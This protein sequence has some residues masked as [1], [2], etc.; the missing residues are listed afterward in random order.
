MFYVGFYFTLLFAPLFNPK[1]RFCCGNKKKSQRCHGFLLHGELIT[2]IVLA[3]IKQHI[4]LA[5]N[6]IEVK[7]FL[8]IIED[9]TY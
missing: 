8:A 1:L 4:S 9:S 3:L 7:F 2:R 6:R 5:I